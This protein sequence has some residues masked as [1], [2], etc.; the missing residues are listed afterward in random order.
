MV[1]MDKL[2]SLSFC[3]GLRKDYLQLMQSVGEVKEYP[4]G[5]H[6][7]Y[8]GQTSKQIYLLLEGEVRLEISMPEHGVMPVQTVQPG[9]LIGWSPLLGLGWMTATAVTVT[10]CR[11]LVLDVLQILELAEDE[12]KFGMEFM[13]RVAVALAKRLN[14]TRLQLLEELCGAAQAVS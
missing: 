8:E 9:E 6:L 12:P 2:D 5:R 7:F 13:R 14:A 4:A 11:L 1:L 10:P 3:K